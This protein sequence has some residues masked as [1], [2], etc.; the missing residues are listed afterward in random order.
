MSDR[1]FELKFKNRLENFQ[2]EPNDAAWDHIVD[3]IDS[4]KKKRGFI[5]MWPAAAAIS[6]I[7]TI[8][9]LL[10]TIVPHPISSQSGKS[11]PELKESLEKDGNMSL[12]LSNIT[13]T[14]SSKLFNNNKDDFKAEE[15]RK[16]RQSM[17]ILSKVNNS[18]F[19]KY[20]VSYHSNKNINSS[21]PKT[22]RSF[23]VIHPE[24]KNNIAL[25]FN[26]SPMLNYS[27]IKSETTDGGIIRHYNNIPMVSFQRLG[28]RASA[29]IV[30]PVSKKLQVIPAI[31]YQYVNI[32]VQ[33]KKVNSTT[34]V[35]AND[36]GSETFSEQFQQHMLGLQ[37]KIN[38]LLKNDLP[39]KSYITVG[40]DYQL[41]LNNENSGLF[42][43]DVGYEMSFAINDQVSF[44]IQP[45]LT[46]QWNPDNGPY[47][48]N[49][50]G[51]GVNFGFNYQ[52]VN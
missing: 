12:V 27:R 11:M 45:A 17:N 15:N 46:Y 8:P 5:Y 26:V 3:A 6:L 49:N 14:N 10:K 47:Q 23:A 35:S 41:P 2:S 30:F 28:F 40:G 33:W 21:N 43:F 9:I 18:S 20:S 1:E 42:N 50:Y 25:R 16:H 24:N 32:P 19:Q 29:G 36:F 48:T 51:I 31:S 13:D 37:V 38:Y 4:N 7:M 44:N 52:L 22:S 34:L 39:F